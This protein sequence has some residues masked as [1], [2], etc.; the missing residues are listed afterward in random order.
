MFKDVVHNVI[1]DFGYG[2]LNRVKDTV[3]IPH[4]AL[5]KRILTQFLF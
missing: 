5:S 3:L 2:A 4:P 1:E